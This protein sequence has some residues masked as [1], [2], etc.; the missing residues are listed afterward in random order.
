MDDN[1]CQ[2]RSAWACR[3]LGSLRTSGPGLD[4][5]SG[6]GSGRNRGTD[7]CRARP[8]S[9]LPSFPVR[10]SAARQGLSTS[11]TCG[12]DLRGLDPRASCRAPHRRGHRAARAHQVGEAGDDA[13]DRVLGL[14]E[15]LLLSFSTQVSTALSGAEPYWAFSSSVHSDTACAVVISTLVVDSVVFLAVSV[16]LATGSLVGAGALGAGVESLPLPLLLLPDPDEPEPALPEP[17]AE[18]APCAL[19]ECLPATAPWL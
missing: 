18:P 19:A 8:A 6:A 1:G 17:G 12:L 2:V 16:V 11:A 3:R 14:G 13:A 15:A 4:R 5:P 10:R 7:R 9:L